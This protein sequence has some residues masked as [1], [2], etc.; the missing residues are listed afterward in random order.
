MLA[1]R[2]GLQWKKE[3]RFVKISQYLRYTKSLRVAGATTPLCSLKS[4]FFNC[5]KFTGKSI[6]WSLSFNKVAE[7]STETLLKRDS[8]ARV[9]LLTLPNYY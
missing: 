7:M 2:Q 3:R 4:V 8:V 5:A 9:F 6:C 1:K